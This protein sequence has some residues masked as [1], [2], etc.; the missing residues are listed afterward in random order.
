MSESSSVSCISNC[1]LISSCRLAH[2][3]VS[4]KNL[5]VLDYSDVETSHT[6]LSSCE[7]RCFDT[8]DSGQLGSFAMPL[9][10]GANLATENGFNVTPQ[11]AHKHHWS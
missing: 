5:I 8:C 2:I 11:F 1:L 9:N 10:A 3:R 6:H 4:V 7:D